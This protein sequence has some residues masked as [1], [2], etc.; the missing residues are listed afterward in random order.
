MDRIS[1]GR[2]I[3][4]AARHLR[5]LRNRRLGEAGCTVGGAHFHVFMFFA[6]HSG[7]SEKQAAEAVGKDKTFVTKAARK[8]E[9]QGMIES[10]RDPQ[11][12]RYKRI[13][14]TPKGQEEFIKADEVLLSLNGIIRGGISDAQIDSFLLTLKDIDRNVLEY[15]EKGMK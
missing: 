3:T 4:A 9:M 11:D 8:L 14:L 15:I 6:R 10:R 7:C 2:E 12:A 13:Y 1:I 5:L